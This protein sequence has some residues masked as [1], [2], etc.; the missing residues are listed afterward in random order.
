MS[1]TQLANY[2]Q[3]ERSQLIRYRNAIVGLVGTGIGGILWRGIIQTARHGY[4]RLS[5]AAV[6]RLEEGMDQLG[7]H[8]Q[9]Q[10]AAVAEEVG[11]YLRGLAEEFDS[12]SNMSIE[13]DGPGGK[14][15]L[16][17]RHG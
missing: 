15:F 16:N 10:V 8:V 14:S 9:D 17:L 13:D 11:E 12:E 7:Q 1:G 4:H 6:Q 5:D 2:N 3:P